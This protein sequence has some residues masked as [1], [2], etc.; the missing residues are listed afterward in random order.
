MSSAFDKYRDWRE[1]IPYTLNS[2]MRFSYQYPR[3][4]ADILRSN[5][6]RF[7]CNSNKHIPA[8]GIGKL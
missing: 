1:A 6:T 7:G 2:T 3:Q 4:P 5:T 8:S